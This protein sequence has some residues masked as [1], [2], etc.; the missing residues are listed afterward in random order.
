MCKYFNILLSKN[1]FPLSSP[2]SNLSPLS[3]FFSSANFSTVTAKGEEEEE[4][5]EEEVQLLLLLLSYI[6]KRKKK[7]QQ[8]VETATREAVYYFE[9]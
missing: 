6:R 5:E 7:E 2:I 1:I 3:P 4:E 9:G 8:T